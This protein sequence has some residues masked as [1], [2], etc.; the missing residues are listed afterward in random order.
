VEHTEKFALKDPDRFK[1]KFAKLIADRPGRDPSELVQRIN[2]GVRYTFIFDDA[3]YSSG[4]MAVSTAIAGAGYELY[5][6][7]N[8][9][10]D[11][12]KVYQGANSTWRDHGNSVLFEVQVHTTAS[13]RAKQDSHQSYEI[14]ESLTS[15]P[16][17]R[18]YT[19]RRQK[20]IFSEVPIP[21]DVA[22]V[23]S[24]RKEGW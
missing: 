23:P 2:D 20:E 12:T 11:S 22:D 7:K 13:W 5:E 15:T 4:V 9:W 6:R 8:S 18:A 17:Q 16:E 19:T 21:L 3:R 24:Y 14:G 1:E 10:A